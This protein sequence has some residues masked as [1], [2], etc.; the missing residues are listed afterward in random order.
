[1][2]TM[3]AWGGLA[4]WGQAA[5]L[6]ILLYVFISILV[7]AVLAA[8]LMFLFAWVREQA[9]QLKKVRPMLVQVNDALIAAQRGE[10]IPNEVADNKVVQVVTQ[11]PRVANRALQTTTNVEQK[12]EAGSERVSDAVIEFRARTEMV[13]TMARAF[14][15]PGLNRPRPLTTE[16][17]I[18]LPEREEVGPPLVVEPHEEEPPMEQEIVIRQS[19]R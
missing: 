19:F 17:Q 14:F 15:L 8:A 7:G 1:M 3:A 4:P 13:K 16:Q 10:A 12:V 18:V 6:V 2:R 5:A 11:V 9:E